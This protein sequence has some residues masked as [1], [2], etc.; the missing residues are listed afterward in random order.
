MFS[1]PGENPIWEKSLE[2]IKNINPDL[3][4]K[5]CLLARP[6]RAHHCKICEK[7]ILKMDHHCPWVANCVGLNNLKY[8]ILFL[9][10][11]TLGDFIAFFCLISKLIYIDIDAKINDNLVYGNKTVS[12]GGNNSNNKTAFDLFFDLKDPLLCFLGIILAFF[13]TVSIGFLFAVQLNNVLK[14]KTTIELKIHEN[15]DSPYKY[16]HWRQNLESVM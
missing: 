14:N 15:K 11:A 2:S 6:E 3:Y 9:F 4:C 1:S 12:K 8:F 13:M 10:Y 16:A 5:K 7:C